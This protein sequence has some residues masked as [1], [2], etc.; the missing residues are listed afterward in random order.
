MGETG[1]FTLGWDW[2]VGSSLNK[3]LGEFPCGSAN[4]EPNWYP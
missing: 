1:S 4:Y 3:E 2:R